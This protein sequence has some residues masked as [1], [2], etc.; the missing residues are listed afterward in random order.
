MSSRIRFAQRGERGMALISSLLLLLVVTI[1]A[2]GMFRGFT[3]EGKIAGNVREKQRALHAAESAQ[4]Y[5]EWWLSQGSNAASITTACKTM[6]DA[7]K[8]EGQVCSNS[9]N[10]TLSAGTAAT[11]VSWPYGVTYLPSSMDPSLISS[12]DPTQKSYYKVPQFYI[13]DM[14]PSFDGN[15]E[16]FKIDALGF[17]ATANTV[18]VVESTFVVSTG[19]ICNTCSP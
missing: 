11:D 4:Q 18:A 19:V 16:I 6:L 10:S 1:L 12:T 5:A 13:A 3:I 14:G 2:V 15:G 9:L 8:L 7:N 17:G